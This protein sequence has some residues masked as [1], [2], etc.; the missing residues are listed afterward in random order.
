MT[1]SRFFTDLLSYLCV[2]PASFLCFLAMR[3]Q[4][5]FRVPRLFLRYLIVFGISIPA[6]AAVDSILGWGNNSAFPL[7]LIVL[8]ISFSRSVEA[9]ICKS[10]SVIMVVVAFMTFPSNVANGYDA[11]LHPTSSIG[12]FSREAAMCQFGLGCLLALILAY[13]FYRHFSYLVDHFH[14]R[15]IWYIT[16]LVSAPF[17]FFHQ[18]ICPQEYETLYTD[19]DFAV[20]W[21]MLGLL[22]YLLIIFCFIFYFIIIDMLK[23]VETR[24]RNRILELQESQYARLSRYIETT[25]KSRHDFR[26]T[27]LTLQGLSNTKEYDRLNAYLNDYIDNLPQNEFVTFCANSALNA[28][29]NHYSAT[30]AQAGIKT[31]WRIDLPGEL[32][33]SDIDL[34]SI[35][36]NILE[37]AI[38]ACREIPEEERKILFDIRTQH[39][40]QLCIVATNSFS[41]KVRRLKGKYLSTKRE[42]DGIGLE[43][44]RETA[45][46]YGGIAEFS[47]S[48]SEFYSDVMIPLKT[49]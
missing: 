44:I 37:N 20:F 48:G 46:K 2:F 25:R 23:A 11:W 45:A 30:A 41:G 7:L 33:V 15:R 27:L 49:E 17:T 10:L 1:L 35:V 12:E 47:H 42:G 9:D 40:A 5:K 39:G 19:N 8:F 6:A 22:F 32:T 38:H 18:V 3:N 34:C 43:S 36:G 4:L 26:Q 13:P 31:D 14:I 16:V 29:L 28:I 24:E 21:S